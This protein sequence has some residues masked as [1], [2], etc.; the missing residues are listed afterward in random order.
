MVTVQEQECWLVAK[1]TSVSERDIIVKLVDL[2]INPDYKSFI[3]ILGNLSSANL[4][5]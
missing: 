2:F 4:V 5:D 3:T 1:L